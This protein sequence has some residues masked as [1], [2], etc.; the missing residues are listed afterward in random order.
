MRTYRL[1]AKAKAQL[2]AEQPDRFAFYLEGNSDTNLLKGEITRRLRLYQIAAVYVNMK[3]A[4]IR[5]FRDLKPEVFSPSG[6]PVCH[7]EEPAF[8]SSREVKDLGMEAAKIR[9]S[10]MAGVLLAPSGIFPVYNSGSS[11]TRWENRSELRV[12][13]L[14]QMELCQRRLH[15]QYQMDDVR[16]LLFGDS[17][18][19]AYELLVG[20]REKKQNYFIL[21]GNYEHFYYLTNNQHGET[22]LRLLCNPSMTA[23]LNRILAQGF[24]EQIP[25]W[26]IENDAIDRNGEPVLFGYFFDLP[27]IARFNAAL[28]LQDKGGTL[29]CFDFQYDVLHRYCTPS[30]CFQTI[31]F[32][33]FNRRFF[34]SENIN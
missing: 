4:D 22:L 8:Y 24:R 27:R 23:E 16:A 18:E 7:I 31:D 13:A 28:G 21:D 19:L 2:M 15:R 32:T 3:L 11:L 9:G 12:K 33:K 30:I 1:T 17:M 34:P 20:G 14:L 6:S 5:I 25:D 10:R 29:V 26:H